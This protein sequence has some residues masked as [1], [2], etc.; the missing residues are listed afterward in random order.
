VGL[1]LDAHGGPGAGVWHSDTGSAF[2]LV[3]A[4]PALES[5]ARGLTEAH[6]ATVVPGGFVVVGGITPPGSRAAARDPLV[7]W[8]PDG[9]TWQR[10][11]LPPTPSDDVMLQVTPFGGGLVAIGTDGRRF[12]WW[13]ADADGENWHAG[14]L[15]G[16]PGDPA[17]VPT[18]SSAVF[19]GS[20]VYS[21][22]AN[23]SRYELWR[24]SPGI[25]W[26]PVTLPVSV[27]SAPVR[28]GPRVAVAAASAGSLMLATDDGQ[29]AAVWF[30]N[31]G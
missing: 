15:F 10:V 26:A 13:N 4:D 22:V 24:G 25:R 5:D 6:A 14:G 16:G 1:R 12:R 30:A 21:V 19:V 18:V 3:D 27:A 29:H 31:V 2:T 17:T 9:G 20:I 28:S 11:A 7:W 8:S 23:T